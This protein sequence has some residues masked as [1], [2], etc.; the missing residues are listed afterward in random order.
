MDM[1]T[2]WSIWTAWRATKGRFLPEPGS[3]LDQPTDV[4]NVLFLLDGLMEKVTQQ[5]LDNKKNGQR[6]DAPNPA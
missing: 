1:E 6:E 5:Y 2:A 3:L 4:M